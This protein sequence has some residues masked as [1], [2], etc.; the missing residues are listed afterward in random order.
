MYCGQR[1]DACGHYAGQHPHLNSLSC[2]LAFCS[3]L[4]SSWRVWSRYFSKASDGRLPKSLILRSSSVRLP[5]NALRL[6]ISISKAFCS[7]CKHKVVGVRQMRLTPWYICTS[8]WWQPLPA[9]SLPASLEPSCC[10]ACMGSY[11]HRSKSIHNQAVNKGLVSYCL[12]S[13]TF[14]AAS[15]CS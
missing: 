7:S 5:C 8:A 4:C 14:T 2:V 11:S 9:H 13:I 6:L 10:L 3:S 1:H 15:L 12:V